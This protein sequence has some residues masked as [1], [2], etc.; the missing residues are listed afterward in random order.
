MKL[1][2]AVFFLNNFKVT[3]TKKTIMNG[4]I[5]NVFLALFTVLLIQ[6]KAIIIITSAITLIN[7][8]SVLIFS[9]R[10]FWSFS[11]GFLAYSFSMIIS[12]VLLNFVIY[13]FQ[14]SLNSFSLI[15]FI[16]LILIETV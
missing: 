14:T 16:V 15:L 13:G 2:S 8:L 4:F 5:V 11:N 1:E 6:N 9:T 7:S 10:K 12:V 3:V